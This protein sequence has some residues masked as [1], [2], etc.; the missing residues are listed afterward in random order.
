MLPVAKG[1][2]HN[3]SRECSLMKRSGKHFVATKRKDLLKLVSLF[4]QANALRETPG[5][6]YKHFKQFA[7]SAMHGL[8]MGKMCKWINKQKYELQIGRKAR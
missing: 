6:H 5:R 1:V 7:Q 2:V 3:V 4:I 8:Q